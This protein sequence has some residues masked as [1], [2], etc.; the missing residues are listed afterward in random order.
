M[1]RVVDLLAART[2]VSVELWPPRTD[3][4]AARLEAT[5]DRR[6]ELAPDFASITYGAAGS[7]RDRTH[8]LVVSLQRD[9][10]TTAMAHLVC[11]AHTRA[12]LESILSRYREEGIENVLALR[13]DPPEG[14]SDG[15][16]DG[17]LGHAIELVELARDVGTFCVAVAAHP[18]GHPGAPDVAT[19]RRRLARKL[20]LA[21]LAVTQFF[22]EVDEYLR[23]VDDLA[24]LGVDRP[25]VPGIM[26]VTSARTLE[27]MAAL[28]G[29]RVP[30]ALADRVA[31]ARGDP[32]E[33]ARVGVAVATELCGALLEAGAPGLHFY[34]MNQFAATLAI[35]DSLGLA[36]RRE[37][38]D[39]DRRAAS[40]LM[41]P[42]VV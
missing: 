34:T 25:V 35:C 7:T 42:P 10:G 36:G 9:R 26:P 13:G 6:A 23:L 1:T 2:C 18:A 30:D 27:R 15:L 14:S 4:A 12:E 41:N 33:I 3:A 24:T 29:A 17:E 11:A 32:D 8:E 19:D 22:Y 37:G 16:A 39:A 20:S 40:P 21:D 38:A 28:S 5:L 31:A